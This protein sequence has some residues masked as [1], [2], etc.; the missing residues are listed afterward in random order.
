MLTL[1]PDDNIPD[2]NWFSFEGLDKIVHALLFAILTYL[3]IQSLLP[4]LRLVQSIAFGVT[5]SAIFGVLI[6]YLQ[7]NYATGRHFEW[8]DI[9]ADIIGCFLG[10]TFWGWLHYSK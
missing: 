9:T 6:E 1:S 10:V 4:K 3:L 5:I 7:E 8:H 2:S